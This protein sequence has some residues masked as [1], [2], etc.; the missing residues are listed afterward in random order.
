M[1]PSG[2]RVEGQ[3]GECPAR[4]SSVGHVCPEAQVGG[5]IGLV[6]DG[7]VITIDADMLKIEVA[8]S[9]EELAAHRAAWVTAA[10]R[11]A[12]RCGGKPKMRRRRSSTV[13]GRM[14]PYGS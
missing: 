7:D 14:D 11:K 10:G 4:S 12:E 13:D 5:P 1:L 9:D 6:R 2:V 3:K 8:V